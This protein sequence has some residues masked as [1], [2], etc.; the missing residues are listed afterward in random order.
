M[1]AQAELPI[2]AHFF[3]AAAQALVVSLVFES[4]H[5]VAGRASA[6]KALV[7]ERDFKARWLDNIL[8]KEILSRLHLLELEKVA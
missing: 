6:K 2:S 3:S 1:A 4:N 7:A 5:F 8:T